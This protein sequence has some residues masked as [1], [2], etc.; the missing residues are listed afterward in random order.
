MRRFAASAAV[1]AG[2]A[3][4]AMPVGG[5]VANAQ[6]RVP[7]SDRTGVLATPDPVPA[8]YIVTLR[9]PP[10]ASGAAASSLSARHG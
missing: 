5:V 7:G 9:T 2:V 10:A 1:I 6:Q 3:A 8:Q 4:F